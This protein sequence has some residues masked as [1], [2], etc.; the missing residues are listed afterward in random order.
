MR[1]ARFLLSVIMITSLCLLYVYQQTEIF[2]LAYA[3][4]KRVSVFQ[5]LLDTNTLLRYNIGKCS[6]LVRIGNKISQSSDFQMP[7]TYQLV[8]LH[9]S[10]E[11][12][13]VA[14]RLPKKESL[15]ARFFGIKRQ[16]EAQTITP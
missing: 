2:T 5:E 8:Q 7:D 1:I 13:K 15:A 11:G 14:G 16:A 9:Y 12:V 10:G 4:Q 6:S 3:A